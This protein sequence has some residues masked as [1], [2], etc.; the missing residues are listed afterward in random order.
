MK[1][2]EE[3]WRSFI[4][5]GSL[6]IDCEYCGKTYFATW[7]ENIYEEGELEE[8]RAKAEENPEKYHEWSDADTISWGILNGKQVVYECCNDEVAKYEQFIWN[9]RYSIASYL[10]VRTDKMVEKAKMEK[11]N[12]DKIKDI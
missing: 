3:F 5:A 11:E 2:S 8:L 12:A 6:V 10:K 4:S 9:H 7:K 1:V